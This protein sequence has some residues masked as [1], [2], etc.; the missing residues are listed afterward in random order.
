MEVTVNDSWRFCCELPIWF[1]YIFIEKLLENILLERPKSRVSGFL[2]FFCLGILG[3]EQAL[4]VAVSSFF[5]MACLFF[6]FFGFLGFFFLA[7]AGSE[8]PGRPGSH[9]YVRSPSP[10]VRAQETMLQQRPSVFQG[11]NGTSVITP[12]D[13][14][15]QL[16][17]MWVP[18]AH[19]DRK[20]RSL[21]HTARSR[22]C[23]RD[24][25][26]MYA[27]LLP[28]VLPPP[29]HVPGGARP[30]RTR[31]WFAFVRRPLPA[32]GPSISQGLPASR[33]STAADALA[34]LVDAAASAPQMEV[35]KTK[36]SKHEASRLEENLR[37]RSAAV[38]EQQQLEQKPLEVEKR[39]VQCLYTSAAFP[40]GKPQPHSSVVYSEAGKDKGPPPKSRYEEELRTRGKTTIT[41]ANFID[42]IIT[43]QIASD[44]DARERG[45][46]SSD[47][48]SSCMYLNLSF[49]MWYLSKELLYSL[50]KAEQ[51]DIKKILIWE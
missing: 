38:S 31:V 24:G 27:S 2:P 39:S 33:Y 36:E 6:F 47:S 35:S 48:S 20:W 15:A 26:G 17:I 29:Q 18:C 10:S 51:Y 30:S 4:N 25:L 19:F 40:S 12:L 46:Q 22:T 43:R 41:A 1:Y 49:A 3:N 7:F 23:D 14:S 16:R 50:G 28:L 21:A 13:P 11:T 45:S 32:G 37:S 44:K 9:G 34:A 8:Q 42:V 5:L